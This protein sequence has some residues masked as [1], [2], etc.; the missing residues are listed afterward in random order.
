MRKILLDAW[1]AVVTEAMAHALPQFSLVKS[2]LQGEERGLL[3]FE[4][5]PKKPLKCGIAFRPLDDAFDVWVGWSINGKFP[6]ATAHETPPPNG[7]WD[8]DHPAVVVPAISLSGRTGSAA[9][10]LWEPTDEQIDNLD[11][12]AQAFVEYSTRD[13]SSQE[14]QEIMMPLVAQAISE[15]RQYGLPYLQLRAADQG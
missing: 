11:S 7:I 9:W 1:T 14:A 10:N 12:F 3:K 13:L 8:F 6:Y 5:V 2:R 4:W 15:V